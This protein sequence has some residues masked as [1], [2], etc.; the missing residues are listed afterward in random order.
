MVTMVTSTVPV[1]GGATAVI[2][3]ALIGVTVVAGVPPN[4]TAIGLDRSVPVIVTVVS[5]A[6][7][8]AV[9]LDCGSRLGGRGVGVVVG[10]AG[11][12]GAGLGW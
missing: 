3:V 6:V 1:P 11:G 7:G 2:L 10:G 4:L 12:A 5:P 9:G 8:P